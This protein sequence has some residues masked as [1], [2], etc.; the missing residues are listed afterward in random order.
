MHLSLN[1]VYLWV[2]PGKTPWENP[3]GTHRNSSGRVE[4]G[5]FFF[6]SKGGE[7]FSFENNSAEPT[8][9]THRICWSFDQWYIALGIIIYAHRS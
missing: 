7:L 1:F 4:I 8:G 6:P 9:N 2:Y 5:Y 3:Q